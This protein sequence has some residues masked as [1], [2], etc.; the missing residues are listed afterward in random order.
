M[1][2]GDDGLTVRVRSARAGEAAVRLRYPT[3]REY[4]QLTDWLAE[5][6]VY[7]SSGQELGRLLELLKP[8]LLEPNDGIEERLTWVDLIWLVRDLIASAT[9]SELDK[10]KSGSPP[11]S[12]PG[13]CAAPAESRVD[14]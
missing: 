13:T 4:A 10:K 3:A 6:P 2:I 7:M 9:L 1:G 5:A 8:L 14:A 11:A 12:N